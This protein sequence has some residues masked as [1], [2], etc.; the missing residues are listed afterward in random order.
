MKLKNARQKI[1]CH[2]MAL[3]LLVNIPVVLNKKAEPSIRATPKAF[4]LIVESQQCVETC[5]TC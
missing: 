3:T 1:T 5:I 4:R 2:A